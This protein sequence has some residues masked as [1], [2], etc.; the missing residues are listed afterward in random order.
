MLDSY[1]RKNAPA[2]EKNRIPLGCLA[3]AVQLLLFSHVYTSEK[4]VYW[5]RNYLKIACHVWVNNSRKRR[6]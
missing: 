6:P 4:T 3:V 2:A 5:G 1:R